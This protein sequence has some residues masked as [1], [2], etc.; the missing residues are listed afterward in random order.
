MVG[1]LVP[2]RKVWDLALADACQVLVSQLSHC[3]LATSQEP[4][5]VLLA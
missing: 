3:P 1:R 4:G 2:A 5:D